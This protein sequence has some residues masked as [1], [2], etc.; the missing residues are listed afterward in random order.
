M[1]YKDKRKVLILK[2]HICCIVTELWIFSFF[3]VNLYNGNLNNIDKN[4]LTCRVSMVFV[5]IW[6][7]LEK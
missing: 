1:E 4:H 7:C 2:G 6:S 5:E 3:Y